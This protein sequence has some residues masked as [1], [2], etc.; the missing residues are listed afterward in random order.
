ML[1]ENE[2]NRSFY[3]LHNPLIIFLP[4]GTWGCSRMPSAS[5]YRTSVGMVV[6]ENRTN[7]T[8]F[9]RGHN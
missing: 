6:S 1:S 3:I 7:F 8:G 9:Q 4:F 2:V 5:F